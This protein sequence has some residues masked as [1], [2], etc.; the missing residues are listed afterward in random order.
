M[1]TAGAPHLTAVAA[2]PGDGRRARLAEEGRR[3][4]A[5]ADSAPSCP[6]PILRCHRREDGVWTG[7]KGLVTEW[8]TRI[9]NS[10]P[11]L[12]RRHRLALSQV[13]PETIPEG[14]PIPRTLTQEAHGD[15]RIRA[16]PADRILRTARGLA[17]L[18]IEAMR[19][20]ATTHAVVVCDDFDEA[21]TVAWRF[22]QEALRLCGADFNLQLVVGVRSESLPRLRREF[23]DGEIRTAGEPPSAGGAPEPG[24]CEKHGNAPS[25]QDALRRAEL[26]EKALEE[27]PET[28]EPRVREL[29]HLFEAAEVPRRA[30]LWKARALVVHNHLNLYEDALE[31]VGPV[32]E[33][34]PAICGD[35]EALWFSVLVALY[36]IHVA[37]GQPEAALSLL[38]T[39][40]LERVRHPHS[41]SRIHYML[42]ML[43]V[44]Y[45]ARRNLGLAEELLQTSIRLVEEAH[46]PKPQELFE[47]AF[48]VNGLALV[49][50]RQG[51]P[52][53]ALDLCHRCLEQIE[54]HFAKGRHA[55]FRSVL[56]HNLAQVYSST[57]ELEEALRWYDAL[58]D[59]DPNYS[60]Y[61]NERGG[62]LLR[63]GRLDA[64]LADFRRA[65]E[66]SSPYAEV[67]TNLGQCLRLRGEHREAVAAYTRALELAPEQ[68]LALVGRAQSLRALE[69]IERAVTDYT[70]AL[71]L[72][73]EEGRVWANRAALHFQTGRLEEALA[74]IERAC[75]LA[76]DDPRLASSR[77]VVLA[78]LARA[79]GEA[80]RTEPP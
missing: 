56:M 38:E 36:G 15:E 77:E 16:F 53:E 46:L 68:V 27:S 32:T 52:Q 26:L 29:I 64:A 79:A 18:W 34:L 22:F 8:A 78:A 3:L 2:T 17:E 58:L 69:E 7:V 24:G 55:L 31:L 20:E 4:G 23:G 76:P 49:R 5:G 25:A 39:F 42:A 11:E 73:P 62:V 6:V 19:A 9:R 33:N 21:S 60:E 47:I 57:G 71:E 45:L 66:L 1:T 72:Q 67:W 70:R 75:R 40:G 48:S 59:L 54:T 61:R 41:R 50:F 43:H 74:D 28:S 14:A 37:T 80:V 35:D 12:L 10:R 44:R 30:L 63:L 13:A 65:V 51:R